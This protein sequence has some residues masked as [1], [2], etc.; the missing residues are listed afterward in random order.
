M[1]HVLAPLHILVAS[2]IPHEHL[3]LQEVIENPHRIFQLFDGVTIPHEG[4]NALW[5]AEGFF[6]VET[7]FQIWPEGIFEGSK[8]RVRKKPFFCGCRRRKIE[9]MGLISRYS[10]EDVCLRYIK[11]LYYLA[12]LTFGLGWAFH[13]LG[14]DR[15]GLAIAFLALSM[16]IVFYLWR[17]I[18]KEFISQRDS[19]S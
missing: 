2:T 6:S 19:R 11:L 16:S 14:E 12:M 1:P 8:R 7:I 3:S 18:K 9:G 4:M 17:V 10:G 13:L 5:L 15:V